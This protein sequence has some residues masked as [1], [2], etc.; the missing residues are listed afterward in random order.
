MYDDLPTWVTDFDSL[1]LFRKD[2]YPPKE[3][4]LS[5]VAKKEVRNLRLWAARTRALSPEE[6]EQEGEANREDH[7]QLAAQ[8]TPP[9]HPPAPAAAASAMQQF[10]PSILAKAAALAKGPP[11][12]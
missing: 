2:I 3:L 10:D 12:C 9:L 1:I 11:V 5:K 7:W 8:P 6:Q 4:L